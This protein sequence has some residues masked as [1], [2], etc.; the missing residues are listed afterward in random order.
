MRN[1]KINYLA[2]GTF[3][4]L[5]LAGFI[6]AIA[7]LTGRTGAAD[8]YYA[9]YD[10]V[11]GVKFG[12]QVL[13]EGYPIGQVEKVTPVEQNGRMRFRVDLEI[14]Q[15]WRI[16]GDS[17]AQIAAP[18][19]LSAITV[20]IV[21]GRSAN[22]LK[23]GDQIPE[24]E[25]ASIFSVMSNV[26]SGLGELTQN[27]IKPL[28]ASITRLLDTD[29]QSL[30]H[31]LAS[32]VTEM[33]TELPVI[34]HNLDE[35]TSKMN[36][37]SDQIQELF[38]PNNRAK[39]EETIN[40]MN[41]AAQDF[42]KLTADLAVTRA[43]ADKLLAN[44]NDAV[45]QSRPDLE[46][47][48]ADLRYVIDSVAKRVESVNQNLEGASRNMYEFSRQIRANPGLLLGSTPPKDTAK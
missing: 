14:K 41:A 10:N 11:T 7:L 8:P 36:A 35:F 33:G 28:L 37:S 6:V 46:K 47:A 3:V 27:D 26:A 21:A 12:T 42:S 30:V 4:V 44:A 16:P 24:Q 29:G 13:Y 25:S 23:P 38:N 43:A 9:V 39:L 40:S 1:N 15:G 18:G 22:A 34:A 2:V 45:T 32:L 19:L 48:L 20:S 5:M 17:R 31:N